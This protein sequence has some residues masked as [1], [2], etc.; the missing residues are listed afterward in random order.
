MVWRRYIFLPLLFVF[1]AQAQNNCRCDEGEKFKPEI[2]RLADNGK[3]DSALL[4]YEK[5]KAQNSN[6]C[7]LFYY[8]GTAQIHF[9][10]KNWVAAWLAISGADEIIKTADCVSTITS[11]HYSITGLY[12]TRINKLD[13]AQWAFLK[14]VEEAEKSDSKYA[15]GRAYGDVAAT[16]FKI[17]DIQK[18]IE[19]DKKAVAAT[20][21]LTDKAGI[22]L[23]AAKMINL[24]SGYLTLFESTG[25][26]KYLDS[27][28][29]IAE[30]SAIAAKKGED[31]KS[32]L[33]SYGILSKYY[34][35]NRDYIQSNIYSDSIIAKHIPGFTNY[36]MYI[37]YYNKS[38]AARENSDI[39]ISAKFADSSQKYAVLFNAQAEIKSLELVYQV[40]RKLNNTNSSLV[41]L[42]RMTMLKDSIFNIDKNKSI[43]ELEKK[44]NQAKNEKTIK[45]L[46]L[47]KLVYA[48]LAIGGLLIAG[49][50]AFYFRQQSLKHKQKILETEQRLN[51]ARMNPHFFF[52]ALT[53]MQRFAMKENDGKALASN[54]S[55]FSNIMRETLESTYKEYV[56][57]KQEVDFLKEYMEIQK[58]RFPQMFSYSLMI[59]GE[60]EPGDVMIPSMI[61]QPFIENSIEHGFAEIDYPG[62][63]RVDFKQHNKKITIEIKDNGKGLTL[64]GNKTNEHI[65]RA[66]Q[67]IKD[68]IYLLNIKLKTKADFSIDNNKEGN[69]V[70]VKIHLPI[71]YTHEN[72]IG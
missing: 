3:L 18:S 39:N 5:V 71:I 17:G 10:K 29:I 62:E 28:K 58:M 64:P 44:Y 42:E 33:E 20:R 38:V 51:R 30:E 36:T 31:I 4:V 40:N 24:S 26:K 46:S 57:V 22:S 72:T 11:K 27:A 34:L 47:Q 63:I 14:A 66:S 70:L 61:V 67:I 48:L 54:L 45:E 56:T 7:L 52:N 59:D 60:M 9:Q 19:Y 35:I 37:A 68:R 8:H 15:L 16:V 69:G 25:N 53:A 13:S 65:S 32:I 55:K 50:V 41:A 1:E 49:L 43:S 2:Y 6:A 21:Q 12:F 23:M